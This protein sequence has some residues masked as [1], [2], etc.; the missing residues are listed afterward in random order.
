MSTG[1]SSYRA[2][3]V[4]ADNELGTLCC[5]DGAADS[6]DA[7]AHLHRRCGRRGAGGVRK[8]VV[9]VRALSLH[10]PVGAGAVAS[11]GMRRR[12]GFYANE[13]GW[14]EGLVCKGVEWGTCERLVRRSS[15]KGLV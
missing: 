9:H 12:S 13:R 4:V 10:H 11:L 15:A 6:T 7:R 1:L 8:A 5:L 2:H 3:K 14:C